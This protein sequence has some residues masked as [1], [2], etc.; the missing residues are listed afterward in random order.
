MS[1]FNSFIKFFKEIFVILF[2]IIELPNA[3]LSQS[4]TSIEISESFSSNVRVIPGKQYDAGW[5]HKLFLGE[6]WRDLWTTEISAPVIDLNK[7]AGGLT[8]TKKG[9]GLQTKSL[10][11]KGND[12]NEY[13]FR[14]IDK[15]PT[16]SL[17]VELQNSVYADIIQDQISIGIPVSSLIAYPMVKEVGILSVEPKLVIFPNDNSLGNFQKDF[18]G[19]L[20]ILELNPRAGKKV[21]NNF[22]GADKIVNGFGIFKELEKDN[23]EQVDATEFLKARLIDIFMGDRDRHADQW[24]WA[25]YSEDGKRIWKPIPRDRDYAFGRYDG[26]FPWLSGL[27]AHSLV[28]FNEDIPD[29][30][31]ITWSGRHLDRRFLNSL[32]KNVWD[33]LSNYLTQKLTDDVLKNAVKKMPTEMYD[34]QGPRLF[35][36]LRNRRGQLKEAAEDFYKI[37]SDVVDV[38]GSDKKE[39]VEVESVD[40][41]KL[42]VRL[43]KKDKETNQKKSE[44]FFKRIFNSDYTREVR[45]HLLDGDDDVQIKGNKDNDIML[46]VIGGEGKDE[47]RNDSD[48]KIKVYDSGNKTKIK[49][50]SSI[51]YNNDKVEIPTKPIEKYEPTIEDRYGFWAFTPILNSNIDDGLIL[52]GGPNFTKHG[53]RANPYLY[54]IELTGA[55]AT[56]AK[57]YDIR[58]YGDF[59]KLIHNSRV[60]IFL[61]ASEL[62]FNRF[63]GFGNETTRNSSLA[64]QNYYK[65]NQ[66]IFYFEPIVSVNA[67]K[68]LKINF[69]ADLEHSDV[70]QTPNTLVSEL[71]PY[72]INKLNLVGISSGFNFDNRDNIVFPTKGINSN[73]KI[74]YTPKLFDNEFN[75]A[76]VSG[77]VVSY[78]TAKT[79]TDITL[80]FKVGGEVIFG[81]YPFYKGAAL[82]GLKNLR[83]FPRDR[84]LGDKLLFGQS[85]LRIYLA[86]LNLFIPSKIGI[87]GLGDIGRVFL[88]GEDSKKWHSTFGGGIWLNT[89]NTFTFNFNV[90]VSPE[91]TRYYFTT[92]FTL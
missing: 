9:G 49:S 64:G 48:L 84:F 55:Y 41:K 43:Y 82:G 71:D 72:G 7:F 20:G 39:F 52:G 42:E 3:L 15:D 31:E 10:R 24:Q 61:K 57:D 17:P 4:D 40:S 34:K 5:F 12:G 32:D 8:P 11:L 26:F 14:S 77:D 53:F 91:V 87:S 75:F 23:D 81:D 54:F 28:G 21:I 78:L 88:K 59:N 2:F 67:S 65:T 25:G 19:D 85:E 89:L 73:F 63:Y 66:Q 56:I 70:K 36:M 6:H 69:S 44:P 47:F 22:A 46:R 33:S 80:I 62:D 58:F 38:Y 90:A 45:L 83:G 18:G 76:K 50:A 1:R 51:Y 37:Y 60:Q 13:K 74:T 29:L 16:K 35:K 86:S 79:F 68:Y 27:L 92:G 30:T